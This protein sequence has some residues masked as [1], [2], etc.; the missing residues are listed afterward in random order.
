MRKKVFCKVLLLGFLFSL[1]LG[2]HNVSWAAEPYVIGFIADITGP[3]S[4]FYY[5]EAEGFRLYI[6]QVNAQ[7]GINGHPVKLIMEDA[8]SDPAKSAAIAKKMIE[9]DKVLGI[10]GLGLSSSQLPIFELA[11]KAGVPVVCGYTCAVNTYKVKPG[12]VVFA[13]GIVMTQ[14]FHSAG[15][16]FAKIVE[17]GYP[18][19]AKIGLSGYATPGGRIWTEWTKERLQKAGYN[20]AYES[21]I[22]PG[23]IEFSPWVNNI[24][25]INPA[26]CTHAEGGEI[27][28]P[29]GPA[30]EKAGYTKDLLLPYGVIERDVE[31]MKAGL[32]GNGEWITWASRYAAAYDS[33]S[34][35]E[36]KSLKKAMDKFGHQIPLSA[37][38]ASGWTIARVVEAALSK[39]GWPGTRANLLAALEKTNLDARGLTGGPIRF[40]HTDHHGPMWWKVYRWND[41]KKA[42]VSTSAWFKLEPSEIVR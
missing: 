14:E 19:T 35:P 38:H 36:Y 21:H 20:I 39:A 29:L 4:S 5:P 15:F 12:S 23:T 1:F 37:M 18:K 33:E 24:A 2:L 11:T 34:I 22:P 13:M 10:F 25:K 9:N 26:V 16:A 3:A 27:L 41:T 30:L 42:L 28:I 40:T 8:K 7:G 6:E 32:M 31:K 17:M